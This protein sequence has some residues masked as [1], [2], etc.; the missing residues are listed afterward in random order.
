MRFRTT[1]TETP[2]SSRWSADERPERGAQRKRGVCGGVRDG[3]KRRLQK[4][5]AKVEN[6]QHMR[7]P[8]LQRPRPAFPKGSAL[9]RHLRIGAVKNKQ[10]HTYRHTEK[11][12]LYCSVDDKC[13]K[14]TK[15]KLQFYLCLRPRLWHVH[16][17]RDGR[18]APGD[19]GL[20][21]G[22]WGGWGKGGLKRLQTNVLLWLPRVAE[23]R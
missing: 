21:R 11:K 2:T 17:R 14:K 23:P 12:L 7:A 15:T 22:R 8:G 10:T 20:C 1:L 4:T 13:D 3:E 9:P 18:R 16:L 6:W 5:W 19:G